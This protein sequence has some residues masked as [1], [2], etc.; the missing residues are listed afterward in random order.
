MPKS[1]RSLKLYDFTAIDWDTKDAPD[2][3]MLH[4]ARH[5]VNRRVVGEVLSGRWVD[6]EM[7]VNT[8]EFAIVGPNA[9]RSVMWT[10]LFDR[11]WKDSNLLRPVTGWESKQKDIRAW[12]KGTREKWRKR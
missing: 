12:E 4:C 10:L 2:S 3:N 8:A 5:G 1:S 11:S 7:L 6:V 9:K